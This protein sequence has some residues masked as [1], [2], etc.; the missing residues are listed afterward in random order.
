MKQC[1]LRP[2]I[3]KNLNDKMMDGNSST[4]FLEKIFDF[5]KSYSK[6]SFCRFVIR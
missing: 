6:R 5:R 4:K 3:S 1:A 2:T